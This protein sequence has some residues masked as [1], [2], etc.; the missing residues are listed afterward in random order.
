MV[1]G[2]KFCGRYIVARKLGFGRSATAWLANDRFKS[3]PVAQNLERTHP[4][5]SQEIYGRLRAPSGNYLYQPHLLNPCPPRWME[6]RL[7]MWR[8]L[9]NYLTGGGASGSLGTGLKKM[10]TRM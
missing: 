9:V 3:R 8:C 7:S 10:E 2:G 1:I 4:F 6:P 5:L